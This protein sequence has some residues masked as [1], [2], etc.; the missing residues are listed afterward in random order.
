VDRLALGGA[1][2]LGANAVKFHIP[3]MGLYEFVNHS[4]HSFFIVLGVSK[5]ANRSKTLELSL[6]SINPVTLPA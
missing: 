4:V 6:V 1:G 3:V 5:T 2:A